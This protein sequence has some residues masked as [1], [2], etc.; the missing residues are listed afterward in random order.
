MAEHESQQPDNRQRHNK[1]T[2]KH[3]FLAIGIPFVLVAGGCFAL[4]ATGDGGGNPEGE[5][6]VACQQAVKERLKA[7]GTADFQAGARETMADRWQVVGSVDAQ[8]G[9]GAKVRTDFTCRVAWHDKTRSAVVQS[10]E[11]QP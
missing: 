3:I 8:N 10:V 5:S 11:I 1:L 6:V 9:F 4:L 7:P 2:P